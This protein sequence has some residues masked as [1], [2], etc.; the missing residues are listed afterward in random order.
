MAASGVK[1][2]PTRW[3]ND[4][5]TVLTSTDPA[6]LREAIGAARVLPAGKPPRKELGAALARVGRNERLSAE[7][8]L[9]ALA[10]AP[11]AVPTVEPALFTF[12]CGELDAAQPMLVR[13]TAATVLA[14]VPLSAP[15]RL[16]LAEKTKTVGALELPKL[17]PA[18]EKSPSEELGLKLVGGLRQSPGV[19]ALR[20]AAL[21]PLFAKYPASV[22]PQ[23]EQ[24]I[25]MIN[26]D[27]AKQ[28][29]HVDELLAGCKEGDIRRGQIVFHSDKAAC[30]LCHTLGYRG[31]R[32]GPD[33]TS[34]GKIRS[35]RELLESIVF[36]S[37][38]FV[39]G[40]EPFAVKMKTGEEVSGILRKDAPDEIILATGPETE[41]RVPRGDI[42]NLQP[43]AASPMPPGYEAMLTKQELADLVAFLKSRS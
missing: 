18:F 38:V 12:L 29:A 43:S 42:V 39:R 20:A 36:P 35:E 40:Y 16:A 37:A 3:F 8:R 30:T 33:L 28:S 17:L 1:E 4:L 10:V 24:L 41:Q 13:G 7:V 22:Q 6:L 25:T 26:A 27:A 15:Q 5:V 11:T 34:I 14:K 2:T 32:L 9:E 21:K 19:S 23:A 31:G